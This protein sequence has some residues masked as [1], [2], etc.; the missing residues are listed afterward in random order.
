MI[1]AWRR[2]IASG[3]RCTLVLGA[4]AVLGRVLMLPVLPHPTPATH[5][6][7]SYLL[8]AETFAAG[9]LSSNPHPLAQFFETFHVLSQPRY[10]SKYPP[11]QAAV[12]AL[13]ILL[14]H[15]HNGVIL[16]FGLF[17]MT[18]VWMLR[19]IV[20]LRWAIFGGTWALLTFNVR[21]Y[22]L[23]SYWGGFA[24]AIGGNL[25]LGSL[26]YWF[27]RERTA[28]RW[29]FAPGALLLAVTRPFEGMAFVIC[30]FLGFF[31]WQFFANRRQFV[32]SARVWVPPVL[33]AMVL[34]VV[35]V[36]GYNWR[37]LGAPLHFPY[38]EYE[39]QYGM[40]PVFWPLP[41]RNDIRFDDPTM[42]SFYT[43]W[44]VDQYRQTR[45]RAPMLLLIP[46]QV[47][48]IAIDGVA[49]VFGLSATAIV[50]ALFCRRNT[51][52]CILGVAF[53]ATT[54]FVSLEVWIFPHY[55]APV[56]GLLIALGVCSLKETHDTI[57]RTGKTPWIVRFTIVLA[58][59]CPFVQSVHFVRDSIQYQEHPRDRIERILKAKDGGHVIFMR[60][61]PSHNTQYEWVYNSPDIDSQRVVWARDRGD[62]NRKLEAYYPG[63]TFWVLDADS[64]LAQL[65]PL[66][67]ASGP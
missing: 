61:S 9:T 56:I 23:E 41:L 47:L 3:W 10:M 42:Q 44:A 6:E 49:G 18:T 25:I 43:G 54:L 63:R 38:V 28:A 65:Q 62:E 33:L 5:D 64:P 40:V 51:T 66:G 19:S 48:R 7:F 50:M 30:T 21:L 46:S 31:V 15:P 39:K 13:G 26:L 37:T 34:V 45:A 16:S 14:G 59:V 24:A 67:H 29:W 8:G 20:P 60:Y 27:C 57:T 52:I 2:V 36:G 32:K 1:S 22:W 17:V 55:L 4:I 12:L 35:I 53:L 11:G 58:L